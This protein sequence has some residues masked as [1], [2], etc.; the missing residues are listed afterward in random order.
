M[1]SNLICNSRVISRPFQVWAL[2]FP[3][4]GVKRS[5]SSFCN[6]HVKTSLLASRQVATRRGQETSRI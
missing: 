5:P 2:S 3:L 1:S 4:G 6:N